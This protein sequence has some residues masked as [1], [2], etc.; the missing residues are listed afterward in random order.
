MQRNTVIIPTVPGYTSAYIRAVLSGA[1]PCPYVLARRLAAI[2]FDLNQLINGL[3]V[4][5]SKSIK[6][7]ES[8]LSP[9]SRSPSPERDGARAVATA[10][11]SPDGR[12]HLKR[13]ARR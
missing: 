8:N 1:R 10:P 9:D 11:V 7:S 3:P 6:K 2:G 13:N 4:S 5:A 12:S